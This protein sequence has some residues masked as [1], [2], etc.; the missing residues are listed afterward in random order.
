MTTG[1]T[2]ENKKELISDTLSYLKRSGGIIDIISFPEKNRVNIV[3]NS[4]IKQID[5]YTVVKYAGIKLSNIIKNVEIETIMSKDEKE[6]HVHVF[7]T[8]NGRLISEKQLQSSGKEIT[9]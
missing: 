5:F 3:C 8:K 4:F 1:K 2:P 7:F 9:D 6:N